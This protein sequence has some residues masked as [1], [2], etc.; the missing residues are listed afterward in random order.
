M[1]RHVMTAAHQGEKTTD[2]ARSTAMIEAQEQGA[3]AKR[4]KSLRS[5]L[6]HEAG[7]GSLTGAREMMTR[8]HRRG[9]LCAIEAG[10]AVLR[11]VTEP[12]TIV[13]G[14]EI[15]VEA[16]PA[17]TGMFL[18]EPPR[19]QLRE[20]L[21]LAGHGMRKMKR[22]K[23]ALGPATE[24]ERTEIEIQGG[25]I[26]DT[27]TVPNPPRLTGTFLEVAAVQMM[28]T[29]PLA[30]GR[31]AEAVLETASARRGSVVGVTVTVSAREG[32]EGAREAVIVSEITEIVG[33]RVG[34]T[35]GG[36]A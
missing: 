1:L 32:I 36:R 24:I 19:R 22:I 27:T 11:D 5:P 34:G 33:G 25:V 3:E 17:S 23:R 9:E 16:H 35:V 13:A 8:A 29:S 2:E 12:V 30:G 10:L 7:R 28:W 14:A 31:G 20:A 15:E 21:P 4:A 26:H 18:V 6:V